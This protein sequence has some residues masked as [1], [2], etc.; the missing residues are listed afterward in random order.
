MMF[1]YKMIPWQLHS[2]LNT[3][4]PDVS[5]FV[6]YYPDYQMQSIWYLRN[7][8]RLQRRPPFIIS[9]LDPHE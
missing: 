3:V 7:D 9:P 5:N 1:F 2:W 4:D 6:Q 8:E